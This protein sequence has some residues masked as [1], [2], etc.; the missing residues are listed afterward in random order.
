[1]RQFEHPTVMDQAESLAISVSHAL[2]LVIQAKGWAVLAVSGGKSPL[3]MFERLRY[4]PIRWDAVTV[5]LV[6]E[7]AVPPDHA[8]SNA[9]LVRHTLLR[10]AAALAA[11]VT[12]LHH[13]VSYRTIVA[14]LEPAA[15]SELDAT[16]QFLRE[17]LARK[18]AWST[19]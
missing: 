2:E 10:E 17:I 3:P 1:M 4:R 14:N 15:R 9:A 6:D 18:P 7:R 13:A 5:T 19:G 11:F 8:D 12:P 16:H